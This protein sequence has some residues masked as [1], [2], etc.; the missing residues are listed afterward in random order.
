MTFE[1]RG[2]LTMVENVLDVA[3]LPFGQG[4]IGKRNALLTAEAKVE[5]GDTLRQYTVA[6]AVANTADCGDERLTVSLGDGTND[7]AVLRKRIVPQ[8]FGGLGLAT[9]KAAVAA[10]AAYLR[11]AKDI[12][13]AYHITVKTLQELG[14][15]DGGHAGCGASGSVEQSVDKAPLLEQLLAAMPVFMPMDE[16]ARQLLGQNGIQKRRRLEEGFYGNW[17]PKNHE[18]FLSQH[19][20]HNFSYLA[21][22]ENDHETHGHNASGIYVLKAAGAG[23]AKNAMIHETNREA[24]TVTTAKMFDIAKKLGGS[25]DEITRITLGFAEDTLDVSNVLVTPGIDVFADAA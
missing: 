15:E 25:K 5:F 21:V 6:L 13:E 1:R 22:D 10:N 7:L 17:N 19:T 24:L 11:D 23:F 20:P 2:E 3:Q 4:L 9:T 8:L 14:E 18:D 16:R 12:T